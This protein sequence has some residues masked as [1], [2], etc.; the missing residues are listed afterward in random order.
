MIDQTI[1]LP[2]MTRGM[3]RCV[4][5]W[6]LPHL[7]DPMARLQA[8]QLAALLESLPEWLTP[9]EAEKIRADSAEARALLERLGEVP[10]A[11]AE[12]ASVD[13]L[14]RENTELKRL[15]ETAAARLRAED[16]PGARERLAE[17]QR[18]FVRSAMT[19][20]GTVE[21]AGTDFAT[22]TSKDSAARGS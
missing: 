10:S 13:A 9:A 20:V 6:I 15:L 5:E 12:D 7:S 18:F 11:T 21:R 16:A 14:M 4:R 3:A 19:E 8:E 17:L 22:L 2:E 1:P